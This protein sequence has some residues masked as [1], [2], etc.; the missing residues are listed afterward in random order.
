MMI[1][2]PLL[3]LCV[4]VTHAWVTPSNLI[5]SSR[6]SRTTPL[7]LV[8]TPELLDTISNSLSIV[9][10]PSSSSSLLLTSEDVAAWRQ[11]VPLIVSALVITD[12]LLGRPVVNAIMA[13]LQAVQEEFVPDETKTNKKERVDTNAIAQ[14]ALDQARTMME[15]K[16]YLDTNK[17]EA[18]KMQEMKDKMDADMVKVDR[19]LQE[20]QKKLDAGEY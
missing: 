6:R 2:A 8:P 1:L 11:Y 14:E 3:L 15:L 12:V 19:K 17:S 7:K 10:T 4:T 18:Q 9:T 16:D 5:V 13:P 20:R